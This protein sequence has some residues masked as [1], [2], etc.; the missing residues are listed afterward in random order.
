MCVLFDKNNVYKTPEIATKVYETFPDRYS[1]MASCLTSISNKA[2]RLE[3][4]GLIRSINNQKQ[5]RVFSGIDAQ[6][7]VDLIT[8]SATVAS[9]ASS[10]IEQPKIVSEDNFSGW[11]IPR[12]YR[13]VHCTINPNS[14]L[15]TVQKSGG[16]DRVCFSFSGNAKKVIFA[17]K[18]RASLYISRKSSKLLLVA[19]EVY[20]VPSWKLTKVDS[21]YKFYVTLQEPYAEIVKKFV[22]NYDLDSLTQTGISTPDSG[23]VKAWCF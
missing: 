20:G 23:S 10:L 14:I 11:V 8:A 2:T 3:K 5:N 17:E 1:S 6:K 12:N 9:K 18:E 7:I 16:R 21:K 22:G 13:N 4:Q 19:G 15:I